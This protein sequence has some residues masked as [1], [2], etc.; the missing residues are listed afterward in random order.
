[1][2]G[3]GRRA[4]ASYV[5]RPSSLVRRTFSM[6]IRPASPSLPPSAGTQESF[7]EPL[8]PAGD[9]DGLRVVQDR[10]DDRRDEQRESRQSDCPPMMTIAIGRGR[11]S[12]RRAPSATGPCR[13]QRRRSSSGSGGAGPVSLEDGLVARHAP[14]RA[15]CS[16]SRPGGS[17]L[18]HDAE[19]HEEAEDRDRCGASRARAASDSSANGNASGSDSRI[20]IGCTKLSN[21]A[22]RIMYMKMMREQEGHD[23]VRL[24]LLHVL[25]MPDEFE[26]VARLHA[27]SPAVARAGSSAPRRSRCR[28]GPRRSRSS[29]AA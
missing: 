22:A 16:C 11:R 9:P 19:E 4:V 6:A 2:M 23:E 20:V 15:G 24:H 13:R 26:A 10:I 14:A 5:P 27:R 3:E 1:M 18:L 17:V 29:A 7:R 8:E 21:C 28:R 12:P 25:R